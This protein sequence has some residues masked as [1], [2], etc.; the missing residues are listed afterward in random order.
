MKA[1][2]LEDLVK[3]VAK[4][5]GTSLE[6]SRV[7]LKELTDVIRDGLEQDGMV[8]LSGLGRFKLRW[9][10]E[11]MGRN[12]QTGAPIRIPAHNKIV[13][14]PEKQLRERV[15][16]P[17]RNRRIKW[18]KSSQEKNGHP[19]RR[20]VSGAV[21][22]LVVLVL[23][24]AFWLYRP[25]SPVPVAVQPDPDPPPADTK[26]AVE[27]TAT[28]NTA[29]TVE[30]TL[31]AGETLWGLADLYYQRPD[32]WPDIYY[33]N[34]VQIANPNKLPVGLSLSFKLL[35]SLDSLSTADSSR[36]SAAYYRVYE[37][38]KSINP[39]ESK[40]FYTV[41]RWYAPENRKIDTETTGD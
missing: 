5:T 20:K 12:P 41:S 11:R 16:K 19:H 18:L 26:P 29:Q 27:K 7:L 40:E 39:K 35:L 25:E 38:L 2:T 14:K 8:H 9:M 32:Y 23:L 33:Q 21:A 4:E 34:H 3:Q 37:S 13:F 24:I 6:A 22:G 30:H 31:G 17:F 15:N 28:V 10:P 1:D 36:L